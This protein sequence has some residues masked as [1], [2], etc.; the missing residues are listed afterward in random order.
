MR[1]MLHYKWHFLCYLGGAA[2]LGLYLAQNFTAAF[3]GS[4]GL[5]YVLMVLATLCVTLGRIMITPQRTR[6]G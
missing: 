1:T 5:Y 6:R 4:T 2:I 3:Q